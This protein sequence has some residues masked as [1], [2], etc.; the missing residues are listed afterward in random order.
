[1]HRSDQK[2]VARKVSLVLPSIVLIRVD[3]HNCLY[4][5]VLKIGKKR[6]SLTT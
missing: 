6:L 3:L 5:F 4:V 2:R 1:M